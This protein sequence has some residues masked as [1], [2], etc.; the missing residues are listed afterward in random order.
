MGLSGFCRSKFQQTASW[1]VYFVILV[2]STM[3]DDDDGGGSDDRDDGGDHSC[4]QLLSL[5]LA[6]NVIQHNI[7]K[8]NGV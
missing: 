5:V 6:G 1:G 7:T 3:D 4:D 8:Y 2:A